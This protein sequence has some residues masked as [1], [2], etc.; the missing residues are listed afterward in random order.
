MLPLV[1][2]LFNVQNLRDAT[3]LK[4]S[5]MYGTT[6]YYAN[7][8][9]LPCTELRDAT[10]LHALFN[11]QNY[12]MLRWLGW[13]VGDWGLG[14]GWGLL[15]FFGVAHLRDASL[16]HALLHLHVVVMLRWQDLLLHLHTVVMLRWPDL[17]LHL[18]TVVLLRWKD[19][20]ALAQRQVVKNRWHAAD[21]QT[22]VGSEEIYFFPIFTEKWSE[23]NPSLRRRCCQYDPV[24]IWRCNLQT[25]TPLVVLKELAKLGKNNDADNCWKV[26]IIK[27]FCCRKTIKTPGA[28]H[29]R[30]LGGLEMF[31]TC[32]IFPFC[33]EFHDPK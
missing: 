25:Y 26:N 21:R 14:G 31:G 4:F 28:S 7:V 2:V 27:T 10:L 15:T 1:H 16:V 19:R 33:W 29:A 5:S 20:L 8:R 24:G 17:L 30:D 9:S 13:G 6:R 11:V 18:H 32:S 12:A 22:M 23:L 3:L